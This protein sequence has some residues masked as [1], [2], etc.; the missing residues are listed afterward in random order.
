MKDDLDE[1]QEEIISNEANVM[2]RLD[3]PN[4]LKLLDYDNNA[5]YLTRT[6]KTVDM[7]YMALEL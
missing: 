1:D 5:S 4:V 2:R 3:H 7:C 6:G